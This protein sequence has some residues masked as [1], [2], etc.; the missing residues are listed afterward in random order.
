MKYALLIYGSDDAYQ[1]LTEEQSKEMYAR[2][3]AFGAKLGSAITGGA[4]LRPPATA[5]TVR[6]QGD[7]PLITDGPFAEATEQLGGLYIVEAKDLDEAIEFAKQVPT[8]PGDAIEVRPL[9]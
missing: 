8:L 6:H 1:R 2:H 9:A 4:E 7:E 5:T 3:D